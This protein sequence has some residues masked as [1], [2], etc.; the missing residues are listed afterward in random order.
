MRFQPFFYSL[1]FALVSIGL[2]SVS[3][4]AWEYEEG[5]SDTEQPRVPVQQQAPVIDIDAGIDVNEVEAYCERLPA[6]E[7][8]KL[9]CRCVHDA[10]DS[11]AY[12]HSAQTKKIYTDWQV[13]LKEAEEKIMKAGD[14]SALTITQNFCDKYYGNPDSVDISANTGT[15]DRA[16]MMPKFTNKQ[17]H[18]DFINAKREAYQM[19][20][21]A[22]DVYCRAFFETR[23]YERI[24]RSHPLAGKTPSQAYAQLRSSTLCAGSNR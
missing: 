20:G 11:M 12:T 18:T 14:I 22:S 6:M 2:M 15:R 19:T 13:Q 3:V 9:G 24:L 10:F 4:G 5:H 1:A 16:Y 23:V 17:E 21:G 7:Q 8:P